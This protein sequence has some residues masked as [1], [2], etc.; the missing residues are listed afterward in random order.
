[1]VII[2]KIEI[3]IKGLSSE[4]LDLFLREYCKFILWYK[5]LSSRAVTVFVICCE[6]PPACSVALLLRGVKQLCNE[7][8]TGFLRDLVWI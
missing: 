5:I 8:C 1:M 6:R 2:L 3:G 7:L 4:H